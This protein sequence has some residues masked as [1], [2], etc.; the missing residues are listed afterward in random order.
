MFANDRHDPHRHAVGV[1]HVGSHEINASN[2]IAAQILISVAPAT[3][4]MTY[5]EELWITSIVYLTLGDVAHRV[6]VLAVSCSR[7]WALQP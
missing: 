2:T 4:A 5:C 7:C 1:R 3:A 6:A